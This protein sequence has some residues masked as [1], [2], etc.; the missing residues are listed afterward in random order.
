MRIMRLIKLD[1]S[2][3]SR[4]S[5][6]EAQA[7]VL[8]DAELLNWDKINIAHRHAFNAFDCLLRHIMSSADPLK[9]EEPFGGKIVVVAGD[10]R[11]LLPVIPN[12]QRA[13]V[14]GAT[15]KRSPVWAHFKVVRFT[16]T[17]RVEPILQPNMRSEP[18]QFLGNWFGIRD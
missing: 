16:R 2:S 4:F 8:R 6:Q 18:S 7:E 9:A 1:S 17:M 5:Y 13:A 3:T 11:Q 15:V 14:F 12:A 10:W